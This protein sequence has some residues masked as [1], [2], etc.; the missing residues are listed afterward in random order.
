MWNSN[1]QESYHYDIQYFGPPHDPKQMGGWGFNIVL[2]SEA[3]IKCAAQPLQAHV[4][5][6]LNEMCN[7]VIRDMWRVPRPIDV[8]WDMYDCE[9]RLTFWEDTM[10]LTNLTVPGNACGLDA[11]HGSFERVLGGESIIGGFKLTPHNVDSRDQAVALMITWLNWFEMV[12]H[13]VLDIEK[14]KS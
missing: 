11:D 2:S 1:G 12:H 5:Q 8:E 4:K 13:L 10:L 6:R 7:P 14:E 3:A 9:P